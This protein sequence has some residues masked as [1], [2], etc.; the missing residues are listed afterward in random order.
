MY[1]VNATYAAR[2]K[3]QEE[4]KCS[5]CGNCCTGCAPIDVT[6]EDLKRIADH[7]GKSLKVAARRHC[8]INPANG[9]LIIKH[10]R[11]CKFYDLKN[12][13]CKIYEARPEICRL[14]PFLGSE[15]VESREFIVPLHCEAA[16]K[17][18]DGMKERGEIV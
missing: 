14:H 16:C 2:L 18:Y 9:S 10:D 11:P 5:D 13:K 15:P 12:K 3:A 4:F 1:Y 8:R 17:V 6:M 7:F